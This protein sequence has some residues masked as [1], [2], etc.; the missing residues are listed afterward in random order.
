MSSKQANAKQKA[1]LTPF[2]RHFGVPPKLLSRCVRPP[3]SLTYLVFR[4]HPWRRQ[5][6]VKGTR[7]LAATVWRD[8]LTHAMTLQEASDNWDLPLAAVQQA[9]AW[10]E[11]HRD[12]LDKEATYARRLI[13]AATNSHVARPIS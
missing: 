3:G 2:G 8:T 5:P 10:C 13:P 4:P 6:W 7:L 9:V 12:L 1:R 11:A